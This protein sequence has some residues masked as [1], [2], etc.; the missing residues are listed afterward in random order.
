[1]IREP[2]TDEG[3]TLIELVIY[4]SLSVVVLLIVGGIFIN[5]LNAERSVRGVNDATNQGQ[6]VAQSVTNGVRNSSDILLTVPVTGAQLL[7]TRSVGSAA[8]P[9]W[10]CSAWYFANGE[11]RTKQSSSAIAVPTAAQLATWTLLNPSVKVNGSNP[12][13][14]KTGRRIDLTFESKNGTSKAILIKTSATSR[15][16]PPAGADSPICF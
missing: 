3:F 11:I 8:T 5:S 9:V 4:V 12:V 15:Q 13:F 2:E 7:M 16:P 14:L 1:M 6:L 10:N